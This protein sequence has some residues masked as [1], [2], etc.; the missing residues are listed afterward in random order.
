VFSSGGGKHSSTRESILYVRDVLI[1]ERVKKIQIEVCGS[2]AVVLLRE[3][4]PWSELSVF[5]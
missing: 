1:E 3:W 5:D 2:L 4:K